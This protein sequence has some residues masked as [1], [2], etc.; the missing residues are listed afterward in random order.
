MADAVSMALDTSLGLKS[1]R[2][3]VA[4]ADQGVVRARAA[5]LPV[6]VYGVSRNTAKSPAQVFPDGTSAIASNNSVSASGRIN[7]SLPWLGGSY[8]VL[9]SGSRFEAAGGNTSTF[10][11]RLGS[12]VS[13]QFD[14]PLWRDFG[15]DANRFELTRTERERSIADLELQQ[16]IVATDADVRQAYLGLLGAIEGRKVAQQNMDLAEQS[17]RNTRARV[18]VGEAPPIDIVNFEASVESNREQLIL[19]DARIA[20]AE[21]ALRQ[22]ILD[23]AR[24][25]YWT[26]HIE[27]TDTIQLTPQQ[28]DTDAAIRN[29]LENRL[30]LQILKRTI[31]I[32]DLGLELGRNLTRPSVDFQLGYTATSTGGTQFVNG[33]TSVRSFGS[34]VNEAFA[35]TYPSWTLGVSVGYPLGR[36]AAQATQAQNQIQK[37]Q[38]ELDLHQRELVVVAAVRQAARDVQTSYQRVQATQAAL[39]ANERQLQAAERRFAV[40]MSDTFELQ[41]RQLQLAGARVS[42]LNAVIAYN[43]ALIEF[44]RVQ[45]IR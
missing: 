36:S 12:S 17:L 32:T 23:S 6:T 19:A 39:A 42:Q 29:A 16:R 27:P 31:A 24:P 18:E 40:G 41:Q 38:Q 30:D 1:E 15:I 13:V 11:P 35:G 3:N 8:A 20:S 45:K 9:W 5:F 37:Q 4:S 7:Q 43:T 33:I 25:D 44:E 14:Q 28:V 10:N 22:Q 34:V 26:L 2:L 21:D